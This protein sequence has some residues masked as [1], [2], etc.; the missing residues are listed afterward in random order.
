MP[1]FSP[2]SAGGIGKATVTATT[3]SPSVDTT[4]RAGKTIYRFTGSGSITIGTA[5]TAETLVVGGGGG[6]ISNN[7][8]NGGAGGYVYNAS[9]ILPAGTLTVTVGGGG[10]GT[11]YTAYRTYS[12][13]AS[14]LGDLY[15]FGGG[16]GGVGSGSDAQSANGGYG[17]SGGGQAYTGYGDMIPGAGVPGQGH[18]GGDRKSVV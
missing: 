11:A 5:G 12:G 6:G 1:L 3:G 10:A 15:G 4:T 7:G 8:G 16:K 13:V 18:S 14:R 2:V 17:G 9:T